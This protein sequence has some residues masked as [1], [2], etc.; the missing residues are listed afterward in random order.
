MVMLVVVPPEELLAP[1]EGVLETPEGHALCGRLMAD[2]IRQLCT[3][4]CGKKDAVE[5]ESA[6]R[7]RLTRAK[8][9]L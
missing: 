5:P 9:S 2:F 1:R 8:E 3:A 4:F 6:L 7:L